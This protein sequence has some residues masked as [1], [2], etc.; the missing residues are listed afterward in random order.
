MAIAD[1]FSVQN[2]GSGDIR[3][4]GDGSTTYTVLELK[5]F[6]G[7]LLDDEQASGDDLADITTETIYERS[8]DQILTL[9]SPFNIDDTAAEHLYDGSITQNDGDD[10]YSGLYV[11]GVVESGT[12]PM[13]VQDNKVLTS[14]WGTGLNPDAAE[15]VI[16][17]IM[18]KSRSGGADINN[19]KVRVLAREFNDSYAEFDVTLGLA[20]ATAAI[21]TSDDLNNDTASATV[22]GW[23]SIVN[24][25][26]FQEL[27]IDGGGAAGQEF[28]SQWDIGT[29]TLNDTYE[30]TKWIQKRAELADSNA[31]T[32][33]NY[34]V[35]N[36]T[37]T[38]TGQEFSARNNNQI[39]VEARFQL[40][41]G[42][43]TPT[44]DMTATLIDSDDASPAAPTGS[45]LA[46][47]EPVDANRLTASYQEVIF[48]FNDAYTLTADQEYF[49]VI[50]HPDGDASNYIHVEGDATSGDDG[51]Y[52]HN[53]AGWTGVSGESL[54]FEVKS[55]PI[56]H[57]IAGE[58]FRGITN[59][60]GWDN[61]GTFT[62]DEILFWGTK[63]TYDTLV[64]GPF[65]VGEY[66][67][68]YDQGTTTVI[69]GGKVLKQTGTILTVALENISGSIIADGDHITGLTSGATA[70]IDTTIQDDTKAG[71]EGLLLALDD[72]TGT[73]EFYMQVL[74]G[75]APVENLEIEGRSSAATADATAV[76]NAR[77]ISPAFVGQSTGSNII[78]AYGIGFDP[79]DVG[80]SDLFFSL[81]TT[82]RQP[83]NNVTFTVAGLVSG[84]DRVLIG[85]RT[86]STLN[87]GLYSLNGLH[88]SAVQTT[89]TVNES[90][91]TETPSE[92][93]TSNS[94]IRVELDT[95]VYK[96]QTYTS[97]TGSVFTIPSTDYSG[98]G[99]ASGNNDVFP[100]YIDILCDAGQESFTA[101]HSTNRDILI[102]IRDG[103]AT[104]IKTIENS[105][106]F[107]GSPQTVTVTRTPDA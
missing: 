65:Q 81:D 103:G 23:T 30:R 88:N 43:G 39:L 94:R 87:K 41:I 47:S 31:E 106:T 37:I 100:S 107:T 71:G 5:N 82:Q 26:G 96:Y 15:N 89:I 28:Y 84:E 97:W 54:A 60:I 105:A 1:D 12:E 18:V 36:A 98:A 25:E 40:K 59:E 48:R 95:G 49:I 61:G 9:N 83:P 69:N 93:T 76:L 20:N 22:E 17:K 102:R 32:G 73:G 21:F 99:Q 91:Q 3:Y 52:A 77:T 78:G 34:V 79:N 68:I 104:P 29:Q 6:L 85:P 19:K 67:K 51:N 14:Y 53:T 75:A 64:G 38:S 101:V 44:G 10:V 56:I 92:G 46:T 62:E 58:L 90:I 72:N 74:Y 86:G 24:T 50:N 55:C 33:D 8:T 42:A 13:I 27:D 57:S 45:V 66:I 80:A 7:N 11:V 35:D 2:D 70:D 4:T 63:I 16:M